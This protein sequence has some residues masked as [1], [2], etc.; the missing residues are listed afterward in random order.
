[1]IKG[2]SFH[3]VNLLNYEQ[4]QKIFIISEVKKKPKFRKRKIHRELMSSKV[5]LRG[6][7]S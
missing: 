7:R 3:D 5:K 1:M 4:E 2:K 6:Q